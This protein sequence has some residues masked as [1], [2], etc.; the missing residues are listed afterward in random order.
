[1]ADILASYLRYE[2]ALKKYLSTF[3]S[4]QQDIDDIAHEAFIRAF[5]TEIRAEVRHPKSLL[6]RAAKHAA[7]NELAKSTNSKTD[8]VEDFADTSVFLDEAQPDGE[9]AL[10]GR[11]KLAA[12]SMVVAGLPPAC[13]K[14]FLLRKFEG[15]SVK[16]IATRQGITVSAVEKHIANGMLKC[17][18][19]LRD[20]GYHPSEFG[21]VAL[22]A[23]DARRAM[24]A[25]K[26]LKDT[27]SVG[28]EM[29]GNKSDE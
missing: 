5:A 14:V 10:D 1:M 11:R 2:R 25:G 27:S 3:F 13:R 29:T 15:L 12:F 23:K 4:R 22:L 7:L 28:G 24:A 17:A 16:E 20:H 26:G 9:A 19:G 18:R 21:A 8:Y 6:F